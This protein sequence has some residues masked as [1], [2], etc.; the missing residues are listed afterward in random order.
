MVDSLGEF[1]YSN[2]SYRAKFSVWFSIM[3]ES[4]FP[5]GLLNAAIEPRRAFTDGQLLRV[6]DGEPQ[7]C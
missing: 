2:V 4:D 6:F 1:D 3:D 7:N 5:R